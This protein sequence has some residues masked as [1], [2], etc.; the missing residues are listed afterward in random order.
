MVVVL[1]VVNLDFVKKGWIILE[2]FGD[3]YSASSGAVFPLNGPIIT[4]NK[5]LYHT[6]TCA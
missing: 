5:R 4:E 3:L 6:E 2:W 1:Y